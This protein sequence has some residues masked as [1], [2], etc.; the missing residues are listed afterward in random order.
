[1]FSARNQ[2]PN[3]SAVKNAITDIGDALGIGTQRRSQEFNSAEAQKTRDWQEQMSNS[4]Y[5]RAVN[6][7]KAAGLNP[8]LM[9]GNGGAESTPSGAT[10][11]SGGGGIG[12]AANIISSAAN[13][14]LANEKN[15]N[16][17]A[18]KSVYNTAAKIAAKVLKAMG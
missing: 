1:M 2:I 3:T 10:A 6:D 4:A 14:I 16:L 7:M 15:K 17:Q 8:A 18:Q 9:Y 13:L 5:Q 11:S 12:S